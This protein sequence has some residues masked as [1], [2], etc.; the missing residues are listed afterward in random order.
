MRGRVRSGPVSA[1]RVVQPKSLRGVCG[2]GGCVCGSLR[3]VC[4]RAGEG[5]EPHRGVREGGWGASEGCAGG[6]RAREGK[7]AAGRWGCGEGILPG[8]LLRQEVWKRQV[9]FY[10]LWS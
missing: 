6:R 9:G 10:M 7:G 4:R 5:W 1:G 8:G 3:G 2:V